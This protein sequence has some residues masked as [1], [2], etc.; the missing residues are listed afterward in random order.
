M[1]ACRMVS[2]HVIVLLALT[3][4]G[5][6]RAESRE[7]AGMITE[8]KLGSGR[9]EVRP[10]GTNDWRPAGPLMSLLAGDVVR[11]SDGAAA[12][13]LLSGGRG[14]IRIE[15]G[16]DPVVIPGP[17]RAATKAQKVQA[18]LSRSF[19]FLSTR[20]RELP[21]AAIGTRAGAPA[22]VVLAPRNSPVLAD[23]LVFEWLGR[24]SGR[25]TLQI[26]GPGGPV[27][28]LKEISGARVEYPSQAPALQP[29]LRYTVRL[30]AGESQ[31]AD[32]A[33]FE[34]LSSDE[35]R[36]VRESLATLNEELA[37]SIPPNTLAVLRAGFLADRGLLDEARRELIGA[38]AQSPNEAT[39]HL[40]LANVYSQIGLPVE[41]RKAFDEAH[42]L[43]GDERQ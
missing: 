5:E 23:A 13:V 35:T 2:A 20:A 26:E 34:V 41:A 39:L 4:I 10:P 24:P 33:W 17:E 21:Y 15:A 31:R 29:G 12:V 42:R 18:I 14:I 9:V 6:V 1:N 30:I 27:L 19:G 25:Y 22:P 28:M 11:A 3:W 32:R 43:V 37:D 36:H 38:L 40:L 7:V 8:I 16:A